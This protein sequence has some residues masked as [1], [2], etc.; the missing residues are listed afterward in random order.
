MN[1]FE[2][3]Y[4]NYSLKNPDFADAN[5]KGEIPPVQKDL[6]EKRPMSYLEYL[7]GGTAWKQLQLWVW[8]WFFLTISL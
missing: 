8:L 1:M 4:A 6:L 2:V 3:P 7:R 5:R